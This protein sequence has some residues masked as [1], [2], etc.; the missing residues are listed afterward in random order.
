MQLNQKIRELQ[1]EN[2]ELKARVK[3]LELARGERL[4]LIRKLQSEIEKNR[5]VLQER[6][7]ESSARYH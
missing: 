2:K 7:L 6:T 3:L 5:Q 1:R 4:K